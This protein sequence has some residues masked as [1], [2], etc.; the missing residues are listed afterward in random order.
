M[1]YNWNWHVFWDMSPDGAGTYFD[2]LLLGLAW[3][4]TTGLAAG[5]LAL[6]L[7]TI[8]GTAATLPSRSVRILANSYIELFRNIPLLAQMFIWYFVLPELLPVD[9]ANWIKGQ[10]YNSFYTAVLS[11]GLYTSSPIAVQI[12]SGLNALGRGQMLAG[13]ALGF[14]L[15]QTYRY[16]LI[17]TVFRILVPP[18]TSEFMGVIKNSAVALTI[19]LMELTARSRAMQEYTFQTFE[20]FTAATIM[21]VII[22]LSVVR[23]MSIVERKVAIPG[24]VTAVSVETS[25]HT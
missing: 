17:P 6:T 18:L 14:N 21:Y 9:I 20:A 24:F 25:E 22:S 19:G 3:T 10:R 13:L 4:L 2:T 12:Y 1:N 8:V 23:I 7:G 15:S 16:I 11:L 5:A